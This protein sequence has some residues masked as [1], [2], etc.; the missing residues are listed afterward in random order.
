MAGQGK[1][2]GEGDGSPP[3][4]AGNSET[5]LASAAGSSSGAAGSPAGLPTPYKGGETKGE[6]LKI[7]NEA[8]KK[9]GVDPATLQV[10]AAQESGLRAGAANSVGSSK[11]LMGFIDGTWEGM[12]KKYG[13]KYGIPP[14]TPQTDP[15]ASALMGAEFIKE[16]M[17][18][19]SA[20]KPNPSGTDAYMAH[21]LG[22]PG[23]KTFFK[24][25][26]NAKGVD[27]LPEAAAKNA[28]S[29]F[30]DGNK[31]KDPRTIAEIYKFKEDALIKRATEFGIPYK[32]GG[33]MGLKSKPEGESGT[34][35]KGGGAGVSPN[36]S[37]T[38]NPAA[39]PDSAPG[40][41]GSSG[42]GIKN[43]LS[44][45]A[46]SGGFMANAKPA[47]Q[48]GTAAGSRITPREAPPAKPPGIDLMAINPE[49]QPKRQE[50]G[51]ANTEGSFGTMES[52]LQQSLVAQEGSLE[53]LKL[54][55]KA[56]SPEQLGKLLTAAAQAGGK[57]PDKKEEAQKQDDFN[58][59]RKVMASSGSLDF[60]RRP[61]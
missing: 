59:Q 3:P 45:S 33:G 54:I 14:G 9:A 39:K 48:A 10:F 58:M 34:G 43:D 30:R 32:G 31:R 12:L 60:S 21:F 28:P 37:S 16:N 49:S 57:Q 36:L 47:D 25:D 1:P 50:R 61:A 53:Q 42:T 13:S 19:V 18:A 7:L 38:G 5:R 56:L 29:F 51:S 11:G 4:S 20:V 15:M 52:I 44:S 40:M 22:A 24:A 41:G 46:S 8:A 26:P 35:L 6:M 55:A 27:V 23:A 17:K 2:E